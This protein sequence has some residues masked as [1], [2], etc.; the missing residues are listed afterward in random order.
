MDTRWISVRDSPMAS[1]ANPFG[2]G[3]GRAEDDVEEERG[4]HHLDDDHR[5][6]RVAAGGAVAVAV[7]GEPAL[8][9][10]EAV[11]AVGDHE[12]HQRRHRGRHHLGDDV[13]RDVA[14]GEP[15]RRGKAHGDRRVEVASAEV[16]H[17]V[18]HGHHAETE[19]ERHAGVADPD[20]RDTGRE[21]RGPAPSEHQPEGAEELGAKSLPER[22]HLGHGR[23]PRLRANIGPE[24]AG[25]HA[26]R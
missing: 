5:E 22:V 20:V 6:Q 12:Q 8:R 23:L 16:T 25:W 9:G 7:G 11:D 26:Y 13:A 4:Q 10:A 18:G 1:G 19:G 3:V 24:G 2:A 15:A 17:G 14:P 21:D